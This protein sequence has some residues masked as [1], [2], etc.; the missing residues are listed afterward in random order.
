[1]ETK[2]PIKKFKEEFVGKAIKSSKKRFEW[3]FIASGKTNKVE[4]I[5]SKMSGKL[6][7]NFNGNLIHYEQK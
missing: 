1:M 4:A 2:I 7:V 3:T 6:R 5:I